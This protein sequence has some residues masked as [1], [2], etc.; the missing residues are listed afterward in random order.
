MNNETL[1]SIYTAHLKAY[2]VAELS[3]ITA[4]LMPSVVMTTPIPIPAF[5]LSQYLSATS[6]STPHLP[7]STDPNANPPRYWDLLIVDDDIG[8]DSSGCPLMISDRP[9]I[10]QDVKHLIRESGLLIELIGERDWERR[11]LNL[12]KLERLIDDDER[13]I[14]GTSRLIEVD[15][16]LYL[17]TAD[18][19]HYGPVEYYL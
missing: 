12:N 10:A 9:S 18:S 15:P 5:D 7:A 17:V 2:I 13:I 11:R 16:E 14:P 6:A 3:A 4:G 8:I 19:V 1:G